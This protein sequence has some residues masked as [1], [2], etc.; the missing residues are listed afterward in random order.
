MSQRTS[1]HVDRFL[2]PLEPERAFTWTARRLAEA[3]AKHLEVR[4]AIAVAKRWLV[5]STSA[6]MLPRIRVRKPSSSIPSCPLVLNR[7]ISAAYLRTL[8]ALSAPGA[9]ERV[10]KM[11]KP[12]ASLARHLR[13]AFDALE[14]DFVAELVRGVERRARED[15]SFD[16]SVG[17]GAASLRKV[18]RQLRGAVPKIPAAA[19]PIPLR[20]SDRQG[21]RGGDGGGSAPPDDAHGGGEP[22]EICSGP[23]DDPTCYVVAVIVVIVVIVIY[24]K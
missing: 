13:T 9:L 23:A 4:D 22:T 15:R 18:I 14:R 20:K 24:C 19:G 17:T 5:R 2:L 12:R 10:E 6:A 7:S 8:S 1:H 16:R 21:D 11:L 3:S